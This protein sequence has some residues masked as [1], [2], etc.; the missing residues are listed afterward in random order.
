MRKPNFRYKIHKTMTTWKDYA[1]IRI[2]PE[3][4]RKI[5]DYQATEIDGIKKSI[6]II[7]EEAI[8]NFL[9]KQK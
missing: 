9:K 1:T 6:R 4:L 2:R 8:L 7:V 3:V 5:R